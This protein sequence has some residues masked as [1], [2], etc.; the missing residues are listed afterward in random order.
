MNGAHDLGVL[1]SVAMSS[2]EGDRVL[3]AKVIDVTATGVNLLI[4]G[5]TLVPDV[6]CADSYRG[7]ASGDWV[8]VRVSAGQPVVMWRL[9]ADVGLEAVASVLWGSGAAPAEYSAVTAVSF[10]RNADGSVNLYLQS[11]D[12]PVYNPVQNIVPLPPT[13]AGSIVRPTDTGMWANGWRDP[14]QMAPAQGVKVTAPSTP[15]TGAWFYGTA[16]ADACTGHTVEGMWLRLTRESENNDGRLAVHLYLHGYESE[17]TP[18]TGLSLDGSPEDVAVLSPG[19]SRRV[20]IPDSWWTILAAGT[21]KGLAVYAGLEPYASF[22]EP[23]LSLA[24]GLSC[25]D[26]E[27]TYS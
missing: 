5:Q 6:P 3:T 26:L 16:I 22:A 1:V 12:A 20:A 2:A 14:I 24:A 17:P 13:T 4:D 21:S 25:G 10:L 19:A 8:A 18:G 23:N 27:I 9:G 7:R 11:A 15:L